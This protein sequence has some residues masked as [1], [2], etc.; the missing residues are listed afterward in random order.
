MSPE[1]LV[2]EQFGYKKSRPTTSSDCYALG[3]VVYETVSGKL[4]F[5]KDTAFTASLKVIRGERPRRGGG[6]NFTEGLWKM[7]ELCWAPDPN[8]RPSIEGVLCCLEAA[9][10]LREPPL[11]YP[12]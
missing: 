1:L 5:H 9:S 2:P 7:L 6:E 10:D 4:P 3:M 8:D 11:P 12:L